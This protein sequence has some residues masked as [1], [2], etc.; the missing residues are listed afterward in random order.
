VGSNNRSLEFS[1]VIQEGGGRLP[2]GMLTKIGTGTLALQGANTYPGITTVNGGVLNVDGSLVGPVT[3]NRGLL[4]GS[5]S[6]GPVTVNSGGQL[7]PGEDMGILNVHGD[8]VMSTSSTYVAVLFGTAVGTEHNQAIVS[9]KINLTKTSLVVRLEYFPAVGD[10]FVIIKNNGLG[11]VKG[12]FNGLTEGK[13]FDVDGLKFRISYKGGDG[14]DVVLS[15][16]R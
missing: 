9:G 7:S 11:P 16:F 1:G 14:N 4:G 3:V 5:G 6:V 10:K 12:K 15:R 2:G 8:L 13:K